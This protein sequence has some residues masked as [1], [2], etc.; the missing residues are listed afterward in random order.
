MKLDLRQD[1]D[2]DDD[3]DDDDDAGDDG[4]AHA[5]VA[6]LLAPLPKPTKSGSGLVFEQ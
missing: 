3:D 6:M 2:D 4:P 1:E 5:Q